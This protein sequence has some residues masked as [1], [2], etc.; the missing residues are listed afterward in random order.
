MPGNQWRATSNPNIAITRKEFWG[1][2]PVAKTTKSGGRK[3][4][5]ATKWKAAEGFIQNAIFGGYPNPNNTR[6]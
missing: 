3:Y 2:K 1:G 6:K 5:S 4:S